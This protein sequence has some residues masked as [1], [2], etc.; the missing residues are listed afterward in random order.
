MGIIAAFSIDLRQIAA[1]NLG[2]PWTHF[3]R[4]TQKV[5][6]NIN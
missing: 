5:F 4:W 1:S 2:I 3:Q 6:L